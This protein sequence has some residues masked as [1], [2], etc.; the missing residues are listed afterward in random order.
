M[1]TLTSVWAPGDPCDLVEAPRV[2][3]ACVFNRA[4]P[5]GVFW[6]E[7]LSHH[8]QRNKQ[9]QDTLVQREEQLSRLQEENNKLREFL[10]SSFVRNVREKS[11]LS[12]KLKRNNERASFQNVPQVSKRVCRNLTAEFCSESPASSEPALD[13]WVLRTLGLKDRDTIDACQQVLEVTPP[14][15]ESGPEGPLSRADWTPQDPGPPVHMSTQFSQ[16]PHF[17][18]SAQQLPSTPR[19]PPVSPRHVSPLPSPVHSGPSRPS[20]LAFSMALS[21]SSSVKTHSFPQGQAFV[22]KDP[23]GRWNFTWVPALASHNALG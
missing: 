15:A 2:W 8:L 4:P 3:E 10:N 7:Q 23:V 6:S 5:A 18:S 1:E 17:C 16:P 22:R 20:D 19:D 12:R 14:P 21:P 11:K 13:L 9:L